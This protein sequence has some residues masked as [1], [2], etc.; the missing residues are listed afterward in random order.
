M[1]SYKL[2]DLVMFFNTH[3]FFSLKIDLLY[4]RKPLVTK[5]FESRMKEEK[6]KV[7]WVK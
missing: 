4:W 2:I 7:Q 5:V 1:Q 3:K 6:V